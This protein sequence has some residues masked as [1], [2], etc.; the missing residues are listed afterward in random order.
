MSAGQA[1]AFDG[2]NT[3]RLLY[4]VSTSTLRWKQGSLSY[5]VGKGITVG[6]MNSYSSSTTLS[7]SISGNII[8]LSGA[9]GYAITLPP[10][11][12]VASG[13]GF[14]FSV[15]ATGAVGITPSGTDHIESGPII[16]HSNDRYHIVSDGTSG[17]HEI[18]WTNAV[19]PRFLGPVVLQSYTVANLPSGMPAGAK[20]YASNGR[21]PGETA[22][23]GSGVEV[24]FDGFHW[25]S[26]C[27]GTTVSA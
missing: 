19:S 25:I 21:K 5:A 8:Y 17:W 11:S 1:I 20:A 9:G 23:G 3:N 24:F 22:G 12:S 14:T 27:A 7:S 18:F 10:A 2:T 13:T 16:L 6:W 26:S 15:N 4:D